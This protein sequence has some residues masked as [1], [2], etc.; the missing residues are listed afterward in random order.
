MKA[1]IPKKCYWEDIGSIER[2][3]KLDIEKIKS[4]M[5]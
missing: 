1:Y 2:Y 3:E 4:I 5:E